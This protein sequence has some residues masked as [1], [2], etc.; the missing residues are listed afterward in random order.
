MLITPP[1]PCVFVIASTEYLQSIQCLLKHSRWIKAQYFLASLHFL[2]CLL[3]AVI[4]LPFSP[5]LL[6]GMN[7]FCLVVGLLFLYNPPKCF[8]L[9]PTFPLSTNVPLG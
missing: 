9:S 1:L 3:L 4:Y 7:S 5:R 8:G 2:S 6:I